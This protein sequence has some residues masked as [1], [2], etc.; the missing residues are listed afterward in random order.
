[1]Q[2]AIV[3]WGAAGW[4]GVPI[5]FVISGFVIAYTA[6][7]RS[8]ISF[9]NSRLSRLWPAMFICSTIAVPILHWGGRPLKSMTWRY[10]RSLVFWPFPPW[11][12]SAYWTLS[13]ELVFYAV[14]FILLCWDAFRRIE[15]IGLALGISSVATWTLYFLPGIFPVSPHLRQLMM[16]LGNSGYARLLLLHHG[17]Y[18]A[19]GV[20]IWVSVVDG[21]T[22][23]R[24]AWMLVFTMACFL[25]ILSEA[26]KV[27]I[28]AYTINPLISIG[29]WAAA[30]LLL[31]SAIYWR[32]PV[33]RMFSRQ[34]RLIRNAV[35]LMILMVAMT[36]IA[37]GGRSDFRLIG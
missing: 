13:I 25:Q 18:F 22:P 33:A 23:R 17:C 26:L 14:I 1:M 9:L 15:Y 28:Y 35:Y 36:L 4:V 24:V 12:A 7:G 6:N 19:L 29:Y 2:Q 8:P 37:G 10:I 27:T 3:T 5:F 32:E 20:F 11:M 30:M 16:A 34:A 21:L 31:A